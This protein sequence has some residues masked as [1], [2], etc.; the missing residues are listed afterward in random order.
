MIYFYSSLKHTSWFI[1]GTS[2]WNKTFKYLNLLSEL[3]TQWGSDLPIDKHQVLSIDFKSMKIVLRKY[4]F[5]K[6]DIKT[7][8]SHRRKIST[9]S[10]CFNLSISFVKDMRTYNFR[11][12]PIVYTYWMLKTSYMWFSGKF[13]ERK[14]ENE[15]I[16]LIMGRKIINIFSLIRTNN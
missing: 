12:I 7:L 11:K 5:K 16:I 9:Y 3:L 15:R 14:S 13:L 2:P 1:M 8:N 4:G 6:K 10:K